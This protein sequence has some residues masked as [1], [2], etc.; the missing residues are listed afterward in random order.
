MAKDLYDLSTMPPGDEGMTEM[1]VFPHPRTRKVIQRFARPL[2]FIAYDPQNVP[3]IA[4]AMLDACQ[5]LGFKVA[6]KVPK[7]KIT[8]EQR[9][10][11]ITRVGHIMRTQLEQNRHPATIARNIVDTILSAID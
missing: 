6:L 11:L 9:A 10:V 8:E 1:V 2:E 5:D 7:R 4:G 3:P